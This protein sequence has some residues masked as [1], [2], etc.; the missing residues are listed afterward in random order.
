MRARSPAGARRAR[1]C[2]RACRVGLSRYG[3]YRFAQLGAGGTLPC[4][5]S[6]L[7]LRSEMR[8]VRS[9]ARGELLSQPSAHQLFV[10]A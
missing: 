7:P 10:A 1:A 8:W 4:L 3:C 5:C 9:P 6:S 2:V